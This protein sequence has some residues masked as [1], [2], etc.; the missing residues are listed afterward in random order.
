MAGFLPMLPFQE[1][2]RKLLLTAWQ[3]GDW[4]R[5]D[6]YNPFAGSASGRPDGRAPKL[7]V[8]PERTGLCH[9]FRVVIS[10]LGYQG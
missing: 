2:P 7:G 8:S 5:V 4:V 1:L 6:G 10:L 9:P 3:L